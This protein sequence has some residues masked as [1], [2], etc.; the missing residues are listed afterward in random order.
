MRNIPCGF[1]SAPTTQKNIGSYIMG[2]SNIWEF[3]SFCWKKIY[4]KRYIISSEHNI[5]LKYIVFISEIPIFHDNL[6]DN[7]SNITI[8]Y[9]T[10]NVDP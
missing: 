4:E 5:F 9:Q 10:E 6:C 1:R 8:K 3:G 2:V 7:L